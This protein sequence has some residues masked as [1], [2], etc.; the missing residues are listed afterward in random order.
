M[1]INQSVFQGSSHTTDH[2]VIVKT[3]TK[4]AK[5]KM[6]RNNPFTILLVKQWYVLLLH[7][8]SSKLLVIIMHNVSIYNMSCNEL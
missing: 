2:I 1:A 8:N 7:T 3:T 5:T 6:L 4:I